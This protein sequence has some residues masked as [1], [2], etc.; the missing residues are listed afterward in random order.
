MRLDRMTIKSQEALQEAQRLVE[1]ENQQTVGVEHLLLTLIDQEGGIVTPVLE[2]IGANVSLIRSQLK[3]AIGKKPRVTGVGAGEVYI[4]PELKNVL[5]SAEK[6]ARELKDEFTST[7]HILMAIAGARAA[8]ASKILASQGVVRDSIL[9]ALETIRGS[10]R[11]TDQMLE[12]SYRS[13]PGGR[14]ITPSSLERRASER[15]P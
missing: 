7:E 5:D 13:S 12:G 11:V 4:D 1:A 2:R 9:K 6:E 3:E 14:K 8:E 15:P 10:Q